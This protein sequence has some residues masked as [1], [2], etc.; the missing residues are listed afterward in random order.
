MVKAFLFM[1]LVSVSATAATSLPV[2]RAVSYLNWKDAQGK[3][4]KASLHVEDKTVRINALE[5]PKANWKKG[6]AAIKSLTSA[7]VSN[8]KACVAGKPYTLRVTKGNKKSVT[9]FGCTDSARFKELEKNISSLQ[10]LL[11]K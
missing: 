10:E 7:Q 11:P 3:E 5:I 4:K 8:K 6:Q 2:Y 1:T 9:E